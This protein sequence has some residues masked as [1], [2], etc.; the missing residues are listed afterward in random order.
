MTGPPSS[1]RGVLVLALAGA[2]AL[3]GCSSDGPDLPDGGI[4]LSEPAT[5]ESPSGRSLLDGFTEVTVVVTTPD[6][7]TEEIC[8]L[9]ADEAAEWAR[10]LMQVTDL[11][12]HAGMVFDFPEERTGTFFMRNTP[13]PLSIAFFDGDGD[14]VS[15]TDMEPCEDRDGC[16]SYAA[17]GPYR[18]A[19]EVPQ[20]DLAGSG[21]VDGSSIELAGA[22]A[23]L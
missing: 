1:V 6:G 8:L 10:G 22:C 16:P 15:S 23:P 12:D 4:D 21:L 17:D 13:M 14:W 9:L 5:A 2:I 20:G 7:S 19:I 18:F 11:G 3:A